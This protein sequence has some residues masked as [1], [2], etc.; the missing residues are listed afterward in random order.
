MVYPMRIPVAIFLSTFLLLSTLNL[1]AEEIWLRTNGPGGGIIFSLIEA[2]SGDLYAGTALGFFRS[3]DGGNSWA[4]LSDNFLSDAARAFAVRPQ[5]DVF[6]GSLSGV[7]HS[8]DN[9]QTW[10]VRGDGLPSDDVFAMTTTS[11]GYVFAGTYGGGVLR[12]DNDGQFWQS[13]NTGISSDRVISLLSNNQNQVFA[14]TRGQGLF[15]S[16]DNGESWSAVPGLTSNGTIGAIVHSLAIN[17]RQEIFAGTEDGLF[18]S[19]DNGATWTKLDSGFVIVVGSNAVLAI[20]FNQQDHIFAGTYNGVFLSIDNGATWAPMND[21]LLLPNGYLVAIFSLLVTESGTVFA[22]SD[23][24]SLFRSDDNGE[25]WSQGDAGLSNSHVSDVV[26][27]DDGT[28]FAATHRGVSFSDD[29]GEN[30]QATEEMLTQSFV[31]DLELDGQNRLLAASSQGIARLDLNT[32]VWTQLLEGEFNAVHVTGDGAILAGSGSCAAS[33]YR[34]VDDGS[35]WTLVSE[36][37]DLVLACGQVR[38]IVS[39]PDGALWVGTNGGIFRSDNNGDL[40][41]GRNNGIEHTSIHDIAFNDAGDIFIAQHGGVYRSNDNGETWMA[42]GANARVD[43]IRS[44]IFDSFGRL[45]AAS[46]EKTVFVS[47]D[48]GQTWSFFQSGLTSNKVLALAFDSHGV[49]YAGTEGSGVYRTAQSVTSVGPAGPQPATFQLF[50]N[51]PNPFNPETRIRFQLAAPA[52][53]EIT[54]YNVLGRRIR[55]LVNQSLSHGLHSLTWDGRNE[56]GQPVANGVYYYRMT[57][58]TLTQT[59]KMMLLR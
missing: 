24:Y 18:R 43:N 16:D 22:G 8:P 44:L 5:G 47:E 29:L 27:S 54:I 59:K 25:S 39:A 15:R 10:F 9:G 13:A 57:T 7:Y 12:S 37:I 50:Q 46:Y 55:T 33:I 11:N 2:A 53:V 40:W 26:I 20:A 45:Y 4:A 21:G 3:Q 1:E 32:G 49:L 52:K 42:A 51:Y 6:V 17:A 41:V 58:G 14:G 36:G 19:V 35:E 48:D 56:S 23:R 38:T 28:V 31:K 34:S 30:W